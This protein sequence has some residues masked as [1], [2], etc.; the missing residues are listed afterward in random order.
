MPDD[1]ILKWDK[2]ETAQGGP[3]REITE[4]DIFVN[5]IFLGY[6]IPNFGTLPARI[7]VRATPRG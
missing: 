4:S 3:F 2:A 6:E 5:G 7:S 1:N